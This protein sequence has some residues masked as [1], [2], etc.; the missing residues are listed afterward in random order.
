MR[1]GFISLLALCCLLFMEA[2]VMV[3]L[4]FYHSN[5][6]Q[7]RMNGDSVQAYYLAESGLHMAM[8]RLRQADF[9]AVTR[10]TAFSVTPDIV[11]QVS[12]DEEVRVYLK[13]DAEKRELLAVGVAG[14][15]CREVYAVLQKSDT[16]DRFVLEKIKK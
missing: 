1:K 7:T 11:Y 16:A 4:L 3:A 12:S 14:E 9:A 13:G 5:M 15:M 10:R 6:Q 2:I 8:V